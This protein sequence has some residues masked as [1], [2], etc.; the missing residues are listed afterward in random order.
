MSRKAVGF[1]EVLGYSVAL[2]A[3]DKACKGAEIKIL[4]IDC[5][6]PVLGDK[7]SIPNVFQVKFSGE[8]SHVRTALDIA[9]E[10]ALKY[11]A[12]EDV[13][14]HCISGQ[15]PGLEKLLGIGKVKEK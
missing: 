4:G 10:V 9:R 13:L 1:L 2:D 8:V 5:N 12:I 6:N 3:M 11:L 15:S 14:T 7:A